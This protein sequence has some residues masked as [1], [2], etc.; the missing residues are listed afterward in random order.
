MSD[1]KITEELR[2]IG[3]KP[4]AKI[5]VKENARKP[6]LAFFV[7]NFNDGQSNHIWKPA[8]ENSIEDLPHV[9]QDR[10]GLYEGIGFNNPVVLNVRWR[11]SIDEDTGRIFLNGTVLAPI[12]GNPVATVSPMPVDKELDEESKEEFYSSLNVEDLPTEVAVA[13][14]PLADPEAVAKAAATLPKPKA[15]F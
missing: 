2:M 4:I 3:A 5:L 1:F 12:T 11:E 9:Y 14:L 8:S 13:L 15:S 6:S 7:T 10:F